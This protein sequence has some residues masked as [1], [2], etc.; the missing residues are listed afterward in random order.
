MF[1]D[2]INRI[3]GYPPRKV[4]TGEELEITSVDLFR[5]NNLFMVETDLIESQI[6]GS[7]TKPVLKIFSQQRGEQA[8]LVNQIFHPVHYC[9]LNKTEI[10]SVRVRITNESGEA[11][12]FDEEGFTC[13]MHI[14][15]KPNV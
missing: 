5:G 3:L 2:Q 13:V 6:W 10:Q 8:T 1:S 11:I 14:R 4:I 12:A 7:N 9:A 15:L